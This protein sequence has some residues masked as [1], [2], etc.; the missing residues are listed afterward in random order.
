MSIVCEQHAVVL[1]KKKRT[2]T[3]KRR[4]Y[5]HTVEN[6]L[7]FIHALDDIMVLSIVNKSYIFVSGETSID[8]DFSTLI[9][10]EERKD[11]AGRSSNLARTRE[12]TLG[13][14]IP[15]S[16]PDG[17]NPFLVFTCRSRPNVR[18]RAFVPAFKPKKERGLRGQPERVFLQNEKG[19]LTI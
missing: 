15:F 6:T 3:S 19:Q 17:S 5:E 2:I 7:E 11:C 10:I 8:D 13:C 9:V 1:C 4:C 12:M 16:M 14:Y 18:C